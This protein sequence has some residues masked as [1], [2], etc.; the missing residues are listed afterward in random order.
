MY[1]YR[2]TTDQFADTIFDILKKSSKKGQLDNISDFC[3]KYKHTPMPGP[4]TGRRAPGFARHILGLVGPAAGSGFCR[5]A[6]QKL[7]IEGNLSV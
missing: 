4:H 1:S 6:R 2:T 3:K 5:T 7:E